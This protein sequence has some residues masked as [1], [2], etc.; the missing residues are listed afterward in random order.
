MQKK[1]KQD[2]LKWIN[3]LFHL[4]RIRSVPFVLKS[5]KKN[6]RIKLSMNQFKRS[7]ILGKPVVDMNISLNVIKFDIKCYKK[8]GEILH[9]K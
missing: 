1:T 2:S 6:Y 8:L 4:D 5:E 3:L 9:L 7:H